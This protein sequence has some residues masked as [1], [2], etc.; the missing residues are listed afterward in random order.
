MRQNTGTSKQK[1]TWKEDKKII[2]ILHNTSKALKKN[3]VQTKNVNE[4]T[5]LTYAPA[6]DIQKKTFKFEHF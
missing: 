5:E 1:L 4:W 6:L 3:K 2:I